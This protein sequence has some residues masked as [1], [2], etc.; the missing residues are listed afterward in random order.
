M[1]KEASERDAES[2]VHNGY[3]HVNGPCCNAAVLF[4]SP[5]HCEFFVNSCHAHVFFE[6]GADP[7]VG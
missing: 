2:K 5:T 4:G 3:A 7:E 6:G 1:A